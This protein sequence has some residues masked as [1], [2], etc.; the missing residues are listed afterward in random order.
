MNSDYSMA[1][2]KTAVTNQGRTGATDVDASVEAAV[3]RLVSAGMS[4]E[5][6]LK[7][8]DDTLYKVLQLLGQAGIGGTSKMRQMNISA[9]M[10]LNALQVEDANA[11]DAHDG[12]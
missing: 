12:I 1:M 3:R 2:V 6:A 8:I 9:G 11:E 7:R 4:R 10:K 5:H